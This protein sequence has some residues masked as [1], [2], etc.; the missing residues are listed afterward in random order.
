MS[1]DESPIPSSSMRVVDVSGEFDSW[2]TRPGR[3]IS[4]SMVDNVRPNGVQYRTP[5]GQSLTKLSQLPSYSSSTKTQSI[6]HKYV[7]TESNIL[8]LSLSLFTLM[9]FPERQS[10]W[11]VTT[12]SRPNIYT[13]LTSWV[14]D[15]YLMWISVYTSNFS[16]AVVLQV[17][18]DQVGQRCYWIHS[19]KAVVTCRQLYSQ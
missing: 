17:E 16:E 13:E 18:S 4:S 12:P 19:D 14:D 7:S 2:Y 15:L 3:T 9:L 5:A 8:S 11:R 6:T 1:M 10:H